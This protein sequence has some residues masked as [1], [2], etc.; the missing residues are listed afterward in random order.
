MELTF[1]TVTTSDGQTDYFE[2]TSAFGAIEQAR[3]VYEGAL[4]V[5]KS[6]YKEWVCGGKCEAHQ[7]I[8]SSIR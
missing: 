6:V 7:Q 1:W 5:R 8:F 2:A 4:S 3:E